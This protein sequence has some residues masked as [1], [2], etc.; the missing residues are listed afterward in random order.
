[1][2]HCE[3]RNHLKPSYTQSALVIQEEI[4]L[5][6]SVLAAVV[7]A[8]HIKDAKYS[9]NGTGIYQGQ[10]SNLSGLNIGEE[11]IKRPLASAK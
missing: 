10:E 9:T 11:T 5:N 6:H 8:I 1:V 3:H 7:E 4:P 2:L